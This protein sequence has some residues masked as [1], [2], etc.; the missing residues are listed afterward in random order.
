MDSDFW[1]RVVRR[2]G[3]IDMTRKV[4]LA[5]TGLNS[6]SIPIGQKRRNEPVA[7]VAYLCAKVL[8]TSVEAL[9]DG[10]EGAEYVRRLVVN[11]GKVF[12]PPARIAD[13]VEG[14]NALSDENL[15]A[16]RALVNGLAGLKKGA[17]K[18]NA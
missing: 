1:N 8:G 7:G 2:L 15:V 10:E 9:V 11:E 14:I 5:K 18:K 17:V 3:E 16:V 4:F 12:T 6:A 13:I